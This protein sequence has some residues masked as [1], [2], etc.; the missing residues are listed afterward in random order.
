MTKNELKDII[1]LNLQAHRRN[2][3]L[4]QA[5]LAER[6]CISPAYYA[7]LEN[8]R[9]SMSLLVLLQLADALN[10]NTDDIVKQASS[11]RSIDSISTLLQDET[12]ESMELIEKMIRIFAER[13]RSI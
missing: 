5:K 7:A 11:K 13:N 2:A 6:A 4:T 3:K 12:D 1:R 9:K 10:I 8:G